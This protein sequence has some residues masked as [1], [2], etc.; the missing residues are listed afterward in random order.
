VKNRIV[1]SAIILVGVFLA[2]FVPQYVKARRLDNE[3]Q[4]ARQES[5]GAKLRDLAGLAYFQANQKNYGLAAATATQLF[6][7]AREV[8]DRTQAANARKALEDVM[9]LRDKVTAELA[10]GDAAVMSDLQEIFTKIRQAT[11]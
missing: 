4:Q 6:S 1:I 3:L 10:K 5:D 7:R 8:A 9:S 11:D 2:S